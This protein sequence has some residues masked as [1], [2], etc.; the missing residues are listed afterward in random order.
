MFI[1]S[2]SFAL[3]AFVSGAALAAPATYDIDPTHTQ[4]YFEINH[5]GFTTQRGHFGQ[6][7]GH[8]V[9]DRKAKRLSVDVT[10]DVNS[11]DTGYDKR[12]A[13]LKSD[14]F[15]DVAKYPTITFKA[16]HARFRGDRPVSVEGDLTMHGVTRPVTLTLTSFRCAPNP[17]MKKDECAADATATIKRSDYGMTAFLPALGDTVQLLI[18][19]ESYKQ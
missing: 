11:L 14:E 8:I 12:D 10:I 7:S 17:M 9:L 15:F 13:H 5:L 18:P 1:R 4:P 6:V 2:A 16:D 3:L 19:V